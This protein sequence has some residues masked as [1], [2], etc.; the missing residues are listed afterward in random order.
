MSTWRDRFP[1]SFWDPAR[2]RRWW[3]FFLLG[4]FSISGFC[5]GIGFYIKYLT[6]PPPVK[7]KTPGPALPPTEP[8]IPS[9]TPVGNYT[10]I[11]PFER[12]YDKSYGAF[13]VGF[14]VGS[15]IPTRIATLL[16]TGSSDSWFNKS[17]GFTTRSKTFE[18]GSGTY[19]MSYMGGDVSGSLGSDMLQ[20]GNYSWKQNFGVVESWGSSIS[21]GLGGLVGLS[22][23][24]CNARKLC[25]IGE[26]E[27]DESVIAFYYDKLSWNGY[28]MGGYISADTYCAPGNL[29]TYTQQ[30]HS[31]YWQSN[32]SIFYNSVSLGTN[33]RAAFD[34]GSTFIIMKKTLADEVLRLSSLT[35]GCTLP[36][37]TVV[38]NGVSFPI[39]SNVLVDIGYSSSNC[40]LRMDSFTSSGYPFD[41]ILGATFL[42][43]VY[44]V[45]DLTNN[46][47]GFCPSKDG[48]ATSRRLEDV[49][50]R[51]SELLD[52]PQRNRRIP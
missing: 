33:I 46:R 11:V 41:V 37:M 34:T 50:E 16:D 47:M 49:D 26:W 32:V 17:D 5:I 1:H 30:T 36:N 39:P 7:A 20:L 52:H 38:I 44:S 10:F 45:F 19:S 35:G 24:G 3:L 13:F 40:K 51:I 25:A 22:R 28:F 15:N 2:R 18:K 42:I 8:S 23:G 12:A 48:L 4:A 29:L 21:Y 6:D 43:T 9:S 31:Y 14:L 27:L